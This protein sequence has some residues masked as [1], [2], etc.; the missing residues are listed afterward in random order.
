LECGHY[1][2]RYSLPQ[3]RARCDDCAK[4]TPKVLPLVTACPCYGTNTLDCGLCLGFQQVEAPTSDVP[5]PGSPGDHIAAL[6]ATCRGDSDLVTIVAKR[7][8]RWL[9][10][11]R[12]IAHLAAPPTPQAEIDHA[13]RRFEIPPFLSER[14]HIYALEAQAVKFPEIRRRVFVEART[15]DHD[16]FRRLMELACA[17]I[18]PEYVT[19]TSRQP[20]AQDPTRKGSPRK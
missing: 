17:F 13:I 15:T 6:W 7:G 1:V 11:H 16:R 18:H 4:K 8:A 9:A 12:V 20:D 2:E 14:S 5:R 19:D 3:K 10:E